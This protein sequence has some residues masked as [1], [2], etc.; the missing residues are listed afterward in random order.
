MTPADFNFATDC[1]RGIH[2]ALA[3]FKRWIGTKTLTPE[4]EVFMGAI[5]RAGVAAKDW[6][7]AKVVRAGQELKDED[8]QV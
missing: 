2:T 4:D 8:P 6:L 1:I 7:R 3:A 5:D